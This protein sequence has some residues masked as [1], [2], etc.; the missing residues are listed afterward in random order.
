MYIA[1]DGNEANTKERV[2]VHQ[3]TYELLW[4][5]WK[6]LKNSKDDVFIEIILKDRPLDDLPEQNNNWKYKIIRGK[7]LWILKNLTPYLYKNRNID[8]FFSPTHYLPPVFGLKKICVI[9]DLGYLKFSGQFKK[10]DFWQL[11]LWTA[12]SINI[13]K[14]IIAV[15][16]FTKNDIVRHYPIA[17]DK[18]DYVYHGF[19]SN[20]FNTHINDKIVRRIKDKYKTGEK[21][22]LFLST[23]KPSKNIEGLIEAFKI[24]QKKHVDYRLVIAGK[25]GW[26]F[27]NVFKSI[28]SDKNGKIIFTGYIKEDDKPA[29]IKGAKSFIL[30]SFWEGFGMDVI[31]SMACGTVVI[32][33]DK[34]SLKEVGEN[35]CIYCDPYNIQDIADKI[36][37]V[38]EMKKK[39]YNIVANKGIERS[40]YFSWEKTAKQTFELLKNIFYENNK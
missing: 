37:Y 2:G 28:N 12:I 8:L 17:S 13:S 33:S 35:V 34:A 6:L 3:Y 11:K 20:R 22:I 30:P 39:D 40:K 19:D 4:G 18:I 31:T 14:Y 21:Y 29:L 23:I 16:E 25:K 26:L 9:H 1:I 36:N 10:Y 32:A 7:G 15:S 5:L 38:I 27:D 24:V